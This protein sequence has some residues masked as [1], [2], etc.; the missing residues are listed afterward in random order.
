MFFIQFFALFFVVCVCVCVFT[1]VRACVLCQSCVVITGM[2]YV[3]QPTCPGWDAFYTQDLLH[4]PTVSGNQSG[5][6][7]LRVTLGFFYICLIA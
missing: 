5:L 1:R 6:N 4:L 7:L 2:R 3:V